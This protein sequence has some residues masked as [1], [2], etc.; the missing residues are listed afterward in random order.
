[1]QRILDEI[2]SNITR[3]K[4]KLIEKDIHNMNKEV[5]I[6]NNTLNSIKKVHDKLLYKKEPIGSC[7][8]AI[9]YLKLQR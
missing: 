1:M 6:M 9:K 8:N 4:I 7:L 2:D 5:D 3:K